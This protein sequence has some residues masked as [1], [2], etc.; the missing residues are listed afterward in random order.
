MSS[1]TS[2]SPQDPEVHRVIREIYADFP[3]FAERC[4]KILPEEVGA[5]LIPLILTMSQWKVWKI[6]EEQWVRT[7]KIRIIQLKSRQV[8]G[9]TFWQAFF[10]YM[11]QKYKGFRA[12]TATH[13]REATVKVFGMD[14]IF[15]DNLPTIP[16]EPPISLRPKAKYST[17]TQLL[18]KP[19]LSSE[20]YVITAG[21]N[22]GRSGTYHAFHAS[23]CAYWKDAGRVFQSVNK[24]IPNV[25]G[26]VIVKESTANGDTGYFRD[27]YW[28]AKAG[29]TDFIAV[30][31]AWFEEDK[32]E[33][34]PS[35][36][37]K[38]TE[39]EVR[40]ARRHLKGLSE[41]KVLRKIAWRRWA[42]TNLCGDSLDQFH[43]DY[44]STDKEAFLASGRTYFKAKDIERALVDTL[45]PHAQGTIE[46][47]RE[48]D[49]SKPELR[50]TPD[51]WIK[52]W[53]FPNPE[54]SYVLFSDVGGISEQSDYH[55]AHLIDHETGR[56]CATLHAHLD[57]DIFAEQLDGLGR[58]YNDALL[59]VERNSGPMNYGPD[60]LKKLAE[61]HQY[62]NLYHI[63]TY[64]SET[65]QH[66]TV[67]GWLTN[68]VTRPIMLSTA[69]RVLRDHRGGPPY[70]GGDRELLSEDDLYEFKDFVYNKA[71][72]PE[73]A[74][75]KHDDRVMSFA[76]AH[77]VREQV[78][79]EQQ[80]Q[81][82]YALPLTF[83]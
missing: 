45:N 55:S 68:S 22:A 79:Y 57:I 27:E 32:Y 10:F 59:A 33:I 44:P 18:F 56:L 78:P 46:Y 12:L 35:P 80:H 64:N 69:Y 48:K 5:G 19:P 52:V 77:T 39:R 20:L 42:I 47:S 17:K 2:L 75:G 14:K 26:T 70:S 61:I 40:I 72:R 30:F 7:G 81:G 15:H 37:F 60:V 83:H 9:T 3:T 38:I 50:P 29:K 63:Q 23:E 66:T 16:T 36:E 58:Y 6:A 54:R 74:E 76:G 25:K 49:E 41:E 11:S 71:G 82:L 8:G 13:E 24:S 53:E 65:Q 4:L 1:E 62:P 34:E 67:P 21:G 73:A 43:Q 28:K 31:V 51:G